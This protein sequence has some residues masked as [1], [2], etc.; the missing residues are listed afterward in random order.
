MREAERRKGQRRREGEG[1]V[2]GTQYIT[3]TIAASLAVTETAPPF[4]PGDLLLLFA[5]GLR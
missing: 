4:A 3:S 2:H 1:G 5:P